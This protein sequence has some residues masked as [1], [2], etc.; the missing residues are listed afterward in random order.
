[1]LISELQEKLE[2][3]KQEYG[4]LEV[5][6]NCF[7]DGEAT[8]VCVVRDQYDDNLACYITDSIRYLIEIEDVEIVRKF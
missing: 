5:F 1:M 8:Y 6:M 4:D 2:K 3:I 7:C